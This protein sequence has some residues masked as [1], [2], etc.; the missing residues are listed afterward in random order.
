MFITVARLGG[1]ASRGSVEHS[2]G[3]E[4]ENV[5]AIPRL[6]CGSPRLYRLRTGH[7]CPDVGFYG[8]G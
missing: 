4:G 2:E 5:V 1:G 6:L 8:A 7:F 3:K